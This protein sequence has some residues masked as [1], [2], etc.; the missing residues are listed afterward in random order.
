MSKSINPLVNA[1]QGAAKGA[2]YSAAPAD[3]SSVD[4]PASVSVVYM[5][6]PGSGEAG[7]VR[8]PP[9]SE[10]PGHIMCFELVQ[11]GTGTIALNY[12]VGE[13]TTT[14]PLSDLFTV[15]SE[16]AVLMS[17]GSKWVVLYEDIA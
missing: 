14:D 4:V 2:T 12:T 16:S 11:D 10:C 8:L 3:A 13:V 15:L 9:P 17:T 7:V 1:L 6:S 5:T